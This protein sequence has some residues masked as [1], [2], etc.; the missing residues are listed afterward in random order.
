[1]NKTHSFSDRLM[2]MHL[3]E[4]G[5]SINYVSTKYGIGFKLLTCL[6]I[7]YKQ[8]GLEALRKKK[9]ICASGELKRT[10]VSDIENNHLSLVEASLKYGASDSRISTW[11]RIARTDGLN[12]LDITKKRG[13]A[14]GMGRPK[15]KAPETELEKLREENLKLKIE[16]ELLKKVK[17]LVEEK[18]ARLRKIGRKPSKD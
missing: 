14:K 1:M 13:R 6:W 15:K 16:N 12:A 3:L 18:E 5:Y 7:Q 9:N 4:D 11:L 10:I 8:H 17:A 2:Y